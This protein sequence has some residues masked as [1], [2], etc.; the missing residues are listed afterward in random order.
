MEESYNNINSRQNNLYIHYQLKRA[1]NEPKLLALF[2][3]F[4]E[5]NSRSVP[6]IDEIK[7]ISAKMSSIKEENSDIM[8]KMIE[9][10]TDRNDYRRELFSYSTPH[11]MGSRELDVKSIATASWIKNLKT[12]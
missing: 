3:K 8:S 10:V 6:Q 12:M 2:N 1:E 9:I 4:R 11:L 5:I 7:E